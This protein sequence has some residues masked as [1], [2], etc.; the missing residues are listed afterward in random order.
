MACVAG[1]EVDGKRRQSEV[2]TSKGHSPGTFQRCSGRDQVYCMYKLNSHNRL[3]TV[4]IVQWPIFFPLNCV[5]WTFI[6]CSFS[7]HLVL[8][9]VVLGPCWWT[10]GDFWVR[11][12]RR[13]LP[14]ALQSVWHVAGGLQAADVDSPHA[15]H[16]CRGSIKGILCRA[17]VSPDLPE[18]S[19]GFPP[20]LPPS[21]PSFS[22]FSLALLPGKEILGE[23]W[24]ERRISSPFL[25]MHY[26][27]SKTIQYNKGTI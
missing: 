14:S 15:P 9:M 7:Q 3:C 24:K 23:V 19:A 1:A 18:E 10:L 8:G 17:P 5:P 6:P 26:P 21:F 25:L 27:I 16:S 12:S 2:R 11:L 20:F 13:M 4:H 22:P